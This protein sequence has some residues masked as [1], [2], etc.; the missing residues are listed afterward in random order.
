[1]VVGV[2]SIGLPSSVRKL[3]G[4]PSTVPMVAKDKRAGF[5]S[6]RALFVAQPAAS[7]NKTEAARR[8][9]RVTVNYPCWPNARIKPC[10]EAASA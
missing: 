8:R 3:P 7:T 9:F 5:S 6:G 4:K 1:M 2:S 10:R